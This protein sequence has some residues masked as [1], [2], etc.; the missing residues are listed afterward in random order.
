MITDNLAPLFAAGQPGVRFRQGT[1]TAWDASTGANT[2]D[3]AGGTLTNVPILN[4]GEAIALKAGHVVGLLG[5]GS[6]WFIVGRITLPG[7]PNFA[8]AS[9]SFAGNFASSTSFAITGSRLPKATVTL[10]APAWAD[11]AVVYATASAALGNPTASAALIDIYAVIN[12]A[13]GV[14]GRSGM[15]PAGAA[16]FQDAGSLM[17]HC[18]QV[19][20]PGATITCTADLQRVTPGGP[21]WGTSTQF[22]G[23]SAIAIYRSTT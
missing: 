8:S 14:A 7:D 3:L 21:D 18:Q 6:A 19:F 16:N 12:G 17:S 10:N 13:V 9:V 23:I 1:V 20:N 15:A 11:E 2:I 5:Q 22:V 4:T